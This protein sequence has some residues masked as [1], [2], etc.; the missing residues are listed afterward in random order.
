MRIAWM[1]IVGL[2]LAGAPLDAS[3]R[4]QDAAQAS[5]PAD[6]DV[7]E[8]Q[9]LF[10]ALDYEHAAPLLDRVIPALEAA[11][12]TPAG[13]ERLA[14]AYEM[15][16]RTRFGLGDREGAAADFRALL[17]IHPAFTWSGQISPRVVA[18]FDEVKKA[19]IGTLALT[20]EPADAIVT[21][22]GEPLTVDPA[23]VLLA[24]GDY[25]F[26]ASRLGYKP[27]EQ[28]VA[29]TAGEITPLAIALE[30]TAATVYLVTS[31][32]DVEILI[33]GTSRGRT[34]AAADPSSDQAS[35]PLVLTDL[36]PGSHEVQ[37]TRDCY[38]T[39]SR[40]LAI[41]ELRD[42]RIE[43]VR[44]T[45]A[46]ATLAI[47]STPAGASVFIDDESKG[48]A[49]VTIEGVCEGERVVELRGPEGRAV[50]RLQVTAG[51]RVAIDGRLK[52][53]FALLPS[54]AGVVAA[55]GT[56]DVR[57]VVEQAMASS[58]Q[59]TV[60]VP[61][62]H[63]LETAL[64]AQ[65]MPPEWLAFDAGGRPV[66]GAATVSMTARRE[67]SER[68]AKTLDAQGVAA[69]SQPSPTSPELVIAL[70][71]AGAGEPDVV[72]LNLESVESVKQAI[73]RFDYVPPIARGSI[74][75]LAIEAADVT[76]LVVARVEPRGTAEQAGIKPGDTLVRADGQAIESGAMLA[77]L[78][79]ER[80]GRSLQ[81]DVVDVAGASRSVTVPVASAPRLMS[82]GDQ[83]LLFNALAVA[84]RT[85][86]AAAPAGEQ[87]YVRLN[88]AVALMRL[89]DFA[90]AREQ[91][92]S[93]QLPAG[94]GIADGTKQYLLGLALAGLGDAPGADRAWQEAARSDASLTE[95]GPLVKGL[96]ERRLASRGAGRSESQP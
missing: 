55:A 65:A 2:A 94:R 12:T 70:L 18:L 54:G 96:A 48:T 3:P 26:S 35:Q 27:M 58:D 81:L 25:T 23:G 73:E 9:R 41:D 66:G 67:L 16:A 78:L 84:L 30:R 50:R 40:P 7:A 5:A 47:E 10:E 39:Q 22:N 83:S 32:A 91:L 6:G 36:G 52:P 24:A 17:G 28:V 53:A 15:R 68:I 90:G 45:A 20:L 63:R 62:G 79:D 93:V 21:V 88:L 80:R 75:A 85:R 19:T 56:T 8:A 38:V 42:Y 37:F 31:P 92:E 71:A 46:V 86:L 14:G 82:V 77:R 95:S 33:D 72:T 44:L 61:V 13:R 57:T 43:P 59:V 11:A 74:G 87:P 1:A 69:I 64:E 29:V 51:E 60:F 34:A 4:A 49:P 76:G 89:G